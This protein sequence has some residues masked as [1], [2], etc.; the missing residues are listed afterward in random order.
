MLNSPANVPSDAADLWYEQVITRV[1][2]AREVDKVVIA[3]SYWR[4]SDD[5]I[6]F[7]CTDAKILEAYRVGRGR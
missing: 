7:V 3:M 2:A 1:D 6:E 4:S 5:D